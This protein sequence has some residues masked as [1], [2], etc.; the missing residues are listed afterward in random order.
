[1]PVQ[2]STAAKRYASYIKLAGHSAVL[3]YCQVQVGIPW[4]QVCVGDNKRVSSALVAIDSNF[5]EG[6]R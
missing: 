1:M 4:N 6:A 2:G 3:S 5:L